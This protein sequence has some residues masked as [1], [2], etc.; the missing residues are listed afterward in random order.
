MIATDTPAVR[1]HDAP[2]A[3]PGGMTFERFGRAE[4]LLLSYAA[5]LL[6]LFLIVAL[7][8]GYP[9][10]IVFAEIGAAS[11]LIGLVVV[12]ATGLR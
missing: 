12:T 3:A 2:E 10:V 8:F 6:E 7:Q 11:A 9:G 4:K 1:D 5:I